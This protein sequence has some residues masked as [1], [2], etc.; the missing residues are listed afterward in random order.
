MKCSFIK[1][2]NVKPMFR[3]EM[4]GWKET[5]RLTK[6]AAQGARGNLF[7]FPHANVMVQL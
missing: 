7:F 4:H 1:T 5:G 2:K 6:L 3:M